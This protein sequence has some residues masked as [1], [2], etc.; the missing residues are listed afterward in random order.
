M[1][2]HLKSFEKLLYKTHTFERK[3]CRKEVAEWV[4]KGRECLIY[5]IL[6]QLM[7]R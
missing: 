3:K 5:N 4:E 2:S 1:E 7:G 6:S